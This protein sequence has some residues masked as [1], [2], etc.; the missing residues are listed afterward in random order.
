[1]IANAV[2]NVLITLGTKLAQGHKDLWQGHKDLQ[3]GHQDLAGS[4]YDPAANPYD[5]AVSPYDPAPISFHVGQHGANLA[6]RWGPKTGPKSI[7]NDWK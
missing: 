4:P 7:K 2:D 1:M 5:P 6:P 3:Q